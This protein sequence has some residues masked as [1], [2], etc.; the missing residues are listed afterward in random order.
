MKKEEVRARIEEIGIIPSVRLSSAEEALFAAEA[1]S[2]GGISI[3]EITMTV[4]GAKDVISHLV[5]RA[6]NMIVGAGDVFDSEVA[7]ECIDAGAMFLTSP[8]FDVRI[9]EFALGASVVVLPGALTPTEVTRAWKSGADFVKVFPC[10]LLG[11]ENYIRALKAPFPTLPLIAA[12]GVNQQ[13]ASNFI[14]AGASGLGIGGEL[15]P[16]EAIRLRQAD[17][18]FT[19]AHLFVKFVQSARSHMPHPRP[20]IVRQA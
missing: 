4:P 7:R 20:E 19:L 6:P 12:G 5:K 11:G 3:V 16:K 13:N 8:G 2:R 9:V 15:I 10:A 18:I 14:L 1:V 17:R